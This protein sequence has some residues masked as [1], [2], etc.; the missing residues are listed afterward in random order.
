MRMCIMGKSTHHIAGLAVG[1]LLHGV[2]GLSAQLGAAGVAGEAVH[3]EDLVHGGA[4]CAFAHH[5]L[6]T[7]GASAWGEG[8]G[9][10]RSGPPSTAPVCPLLALHT[11]TR[12]RF[13]L[14]HTHTQSHTQHIHRHTLHYTDKYTD[15]HT[16]IN[17]TK[18][19]H[20]QHIYRQTQKN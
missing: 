10:S 5:V 1:L 11:D 4:A 2:E 15:K 17:T 6:P 14:I 12:A 18:V 16:Q 20:T 9:E 19:S 13:S 8:R 3:M 7:G